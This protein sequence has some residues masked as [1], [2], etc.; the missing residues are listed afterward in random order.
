MKLNNARRI[1][2]AVFAELYDRAE[3]DWW[4]DGIDEDTQKEISGK[5]ITIISKFLPDDV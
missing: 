1:W 4:W 5:M 2:K 3:F